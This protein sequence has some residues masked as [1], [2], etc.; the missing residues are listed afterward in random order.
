MNFRK[1]KI[2]NTFECQLSE[3]LWKWGEVWGK[4]YLFQGFKNRLRQQKNL[5]DWNYTVPVIRSQVSDQKKWILLQKNELFLSKWHQI[6]LKKTVPIRR[7]E[8]EVNLCTIYNFP[9]EVGGVHWIIGKSIDL[10][11][12]VS[13]SKIWKSW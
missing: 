5:K 6:M 3:N 4:R 10:A 1:S 13:L 9:Q 8:K 11:G 7:F 2:I 12:F